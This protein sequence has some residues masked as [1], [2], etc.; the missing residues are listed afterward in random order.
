VAHGQRQLWTM[1]EL[2]RYLRENP[3]EVWPPVGVKVGERLV[4]IWTKHLTT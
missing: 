1:K 2:H 4:P 3:D